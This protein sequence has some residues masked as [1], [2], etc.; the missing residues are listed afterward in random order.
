M[1]KAA[2]FDL[3]GTLLDRDESVKQ[4]ID[5]QYNRFAKLKNFVSKEKY[6]KRFIELDHRGYVWKD[7]VYQQIVYEFSLPEPSWEDLLTDYINE[8]KNSCVPFPHL[9]EMLENLKSKNY[10]LGII[11]NGFGQFQIDNIK[12]L[13]IKEYFDMI[14]I[15]EWE[16]IKKPDPRIFKRALEHLQVSPYESI[17]VGDHPENDVK[18]AQDVG[19]KGIWKRDA[20]WEDVEADY[21]VNELSEIP[22]IIEKMNS[23]CVT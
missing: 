23:A 22:F 10:K 8:F 13:G 5:E 20:H 12:A 17:F 3:D 14:L 21:I 9:I 15:S 18:A 6:V 11:S 1:I 16:G 4:F 19:M 7:K 2:L